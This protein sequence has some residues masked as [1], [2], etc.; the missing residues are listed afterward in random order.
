MTRKGI[1]IFL[2][3]IFLVWGAGFGACSW[4]KGSLESEVRNYL[5]KQGYKNEEI[6]SIHTRVGKAPVF[7]IEVIFVDEPQTV[8]YYRKSDGKIIQYGAPT[9]M[10]G[11][12]TAEDEIFIHR[13]DN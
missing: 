13:E 7:S 2:L 1:I 8:Y 10:E 12:N 4:K 5:F 11:R 3:V 9:D 6:Q